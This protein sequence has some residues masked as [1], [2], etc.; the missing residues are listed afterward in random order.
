MTRI[1]KHYGHRVVNDCSCQLDICLN[2]PSEAWNRFLDI[3]RV[4]NLMFDEKMFYTTIVLNCF[5][6]QNRN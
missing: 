6:G 1:T 5:N 2:K 3:L 4:I